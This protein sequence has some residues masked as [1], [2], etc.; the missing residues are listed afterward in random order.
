[1]DA[2]KPISCCLMIGGPAHGKCFGLSPRTIVIVPFPVPEVGGAA[3]ITYTRVGSAYTVHEN[4]GKLDQVQ[5]FMEAGHEF[6]GD[7]QGQFMFTDL[8]F[9]AAHFPEQFRVEALL[10]VLRKTLY[11]I[12]QEL[13]DELSIGLSKY[14]R[15]LDAA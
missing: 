14:V 9:N 11:E 2:L 4:L 12:G 10:Q 1:M 7:T 3:E 5:L 13:D 15:Q 8:L 6:P